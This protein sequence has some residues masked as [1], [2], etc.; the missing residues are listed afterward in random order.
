MTVGELKKLFRDGNIAIRYYDPVAND[1]KTKYVVRYA[2]IDNS[3]DE[4]VVDYCTINVETLHTIGGNI[5]LER[6]L[7]TLKMEEQK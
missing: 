2:V 5:P 1:M 4:R 3:F 7:A 6:I